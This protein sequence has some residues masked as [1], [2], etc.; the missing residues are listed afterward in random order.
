MRR[1]RQVS[2]STDGA[3][4]NELVRQ[5]KHVS[6]LALDTCDEQAEKEENRRVPHV[7][8]VRFGHKTTRGTRLGAP[9]T[10]TSLCPVLPNRRLTSPFQQT[11]FFGMCD[12]MAA[13]KIASCAS[14]AT[15]IPVNCW[16][17]EPRVL[18]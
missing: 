11:Q 5:Q 13:A 16:A 7:A 9:Q 12:D 2:D 14:S 17:R 18:E 6:M 15:R 8:H 10:G 1:A 4:A 3:R